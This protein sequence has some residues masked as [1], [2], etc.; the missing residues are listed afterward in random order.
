MVFDKKV[1]IIIPCYNEEEIIQKTHV[2]VKNVLDKCN[3]S[4][5]EI[6]YINDGS[7]DRTLEILEE[8][9]K[10]D[11]AVKVICFSRNFENA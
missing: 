7:F 10:E 4:S 6:I 11:K 9:A 5:Y 8:I 3:L 2:R 1:S